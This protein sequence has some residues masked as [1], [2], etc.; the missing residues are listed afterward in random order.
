M[1]NLEI[2]NRKK[3]L[4]VDD[5]EDVL[6]TLKDYFDMCVLDTARYFEDA[7]ELLDKNEYDLAIFDIM[8]VDGHVLL[9]IAGRKGIPAL[10][11]T[12]H[13]LSRDSFVKSIEGGAKAY[14]PKEKMSETAMYAA[15]ILR[16]HERGIKHS[17]KWFKRLRSV[18]DRQFGQ[19]WIE[20][21]QAFKDKYD[22]LIV[23][24]D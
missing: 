23:P 5:E 13:S 3:L 12:A 22:W 4:I 21:D 20:K 10:M 17:N 14:I 24:R 1:E 7:K 6:E 2:L 8:G 19:G 18:F 16:D 9:Q 11:L 15:E